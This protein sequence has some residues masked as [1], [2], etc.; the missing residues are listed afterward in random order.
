MP[1]FPTNLRVQNTLTACENKPFV[2]NYNSIEK[3]EVVKTTSPK[4]K[5]NKEWLFV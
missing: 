2:L 4:R 3:E 5:K 1:S